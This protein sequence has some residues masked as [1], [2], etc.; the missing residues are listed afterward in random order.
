[1]DDFYDMNDKIGKSFPLARIE[2][3]DSQKTLYFKI[4]KRNILPGQ[5]FMIHYGNCQK[6]ISVSHYNGNGIGFTIQDR[7]DC[8]RSMLSADTGAYFGLTGPLGNHFDV[9]NYKKLL[10]IG[11]G[12]GTAPVY[13]L[14]T[15]LSEKKINTDVIFGAR[16]KELLE[17]TFPHKD[18]IRYYTDDGSYGTKGFL[19]QGIDELN[20]AYYDCACICGPEK[21]MPFLLDKLKNRCGKILISMERYMKCGL[22][23]CGSCVLD[24]IG[25]R[26]C[27][28]GPVFD[29]ESVLKMSG[30]F[31]A[32]HRNESGIIQ[33]Y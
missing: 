29:Y 17:Y 28:E 25:M 13:Y 9:K 1:M 33:K 21:M 6:P 7:G 19:T 31:T 20:G 5:F 23:L 22:G 3:G 4:G 15:T 12:I 16:S 27:A 30:E 24:D 2:G 18:D 8:T 14:A 26:V 11:G 32:Y 10:L